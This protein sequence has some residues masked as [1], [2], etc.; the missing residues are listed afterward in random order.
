MTPVIPPSLKMPASFSTTKPCSPNFGHWI[1]TALSLRK[2][3][4]KSPKATGAQSAAISRFFPL[5]NGRRRRHEL[6]LDRP[7]A[8]LGADLARGGRR[9][10]RG[11]IVADQARRRAPA[12][13]VAVARRLRALAV[14]VLLAVVVPPW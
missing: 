9:R 11:A 5:K 6:Q 13:V 8:E 4:W 14:M 3:R 7:V 2:R 10:G 1:T 12:A